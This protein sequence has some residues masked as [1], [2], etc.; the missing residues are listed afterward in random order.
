MWDD[1]LDAGDPSRTCASAIVRDDEPVRAG[2]PDRCLQAAG[3]R[4]TRMAR[5]S[6]ADERRRQIVAATI[7]TI[8]EHGIAGASLDRI[9]TEVGMSRGHVRHFVGNREELLRE[10]ARRFFYDGTDGESVLPADVD[11]VASAVDFLF[12]ES[13]AAAGTENA[14]VIGLVEA[15]RTDTVIAEVLTT[16]YE[17]THRRIAAMLAAEH[18]DADPGLRRTVAYGIVAS[19][20]HNVFLNDIASVSTVDPDAR[21]SAELLIASLG[22]YV[23][24]VGGPDERE[25]R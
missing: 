21:R 2:A 13:F 22:P 15:A 20:L 11:T 5:P 8:G 1:R 23:G 4:E 18:P 10:S 12:S 17:G 6:V 3:R 16:A 25:T 9:A 19:A 24:E 14:V 7:R